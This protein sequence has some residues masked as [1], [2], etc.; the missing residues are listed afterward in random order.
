MP[1][2]SPQVGDA[3][4]RLRRVARCADLPISVRAP[5]H[6][7]R[8][9]GTARRQCGGRTAVG[10]TVTMRHS[11]RRQ[12]LLRTSSARSA[13]QRPDGAP[14]AAGLGRTQS[15]HGTRRRS[16][17]AAR[18]RRTAPLRRTGPLAAGRTADIRP[19]AIDSRCHVEAEAT[20]FTNIAPGSA[21]VV[22]P[23][24]E[25]LRNVG[26][27]GF[28]ETQGRRRQ[29]CRRRH[30]RSHRAAPRGGVGGRCWWRRPTVRR[31]GYRWRRS[32][33]RRQPRF[34]CSD[35]ANMRVGR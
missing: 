7:I 11:P 26:F 15:R 25:A 28:R 18:P 29:R 23:W 17:V 12:R 22:R 3:E 8:R 31:S 35:F 1:S 6:Q 4:P 27:R 14:S 5:D 10:A 30:A 21:D 33:R 19:R 32:P 24:V 20:V 16:S 34:R 2:R 13:D 9:Q